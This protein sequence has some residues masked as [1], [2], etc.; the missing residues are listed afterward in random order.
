ML[1]QNN[2]GKGWDPNDYWNVP[3]QTLGL[4]GILRKIQ[5]A[6]PNIS[7]TILTRGHVVRCTIIVYIVSNYKPELE[8]VPSVR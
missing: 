8:A 5:S 1:V 4:G 7:S 6:E 3:S 2:D